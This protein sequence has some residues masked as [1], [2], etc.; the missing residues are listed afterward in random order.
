MAIPGGREIDCLPIG[1]PVGPVLRV[2]LRDLDPGALRNWSRPIHRG[3]HNPRAIG[4]NPLRETDPPIVGR[5]AAV[6]KL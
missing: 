4:L 3:D 5:E 1:G 6:Q 2:F